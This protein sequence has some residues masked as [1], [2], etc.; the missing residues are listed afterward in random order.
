MGYAAQGA[1]SMQC[2]LRCA[3]VD[4]AQSLVPDGVWTAV[5]FDNSFPRVILEASPFYKKY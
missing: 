5:P 3:I 4:A 2:V 1:Q